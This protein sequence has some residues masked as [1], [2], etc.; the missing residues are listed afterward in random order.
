MLERLMT[1]CDLYKKKDGKYNPNYI[2]KLVQNYRSHKDILHIPNTHFYDGDL[3]CY[4]QPDTQI[5]LNWKK[6]PGKK[7]PIIFQEV[8]GVEEKT[9]TKRLVI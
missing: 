9:E 1:D 4:E 3:V 2:T 6:L 8:L 5:A 7:F